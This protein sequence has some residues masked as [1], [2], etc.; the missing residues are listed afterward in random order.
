MDFQNLNTYAYG[1]WPVVAFNIALFAFFAIS[2]IKPKKKVEWGTMGVFI[3]FLAAL[4]TEMYGFPLT[5]F[6]L[7]SYLGVNYPALNP[8]SH[9]SG[10]LTLVFLGLDQSIISLI[11]LHLIS[12]TIIFL[13]LY[14]LHNGWKGIYASKGKQLVK[15]GIYAKIRHPQY[16]GLFLVTIGF[17]IQWP[18]ITTVLMWPILMFAYYRLS[19]REEGD[20]IKKF[21]KE[22]LQ[23]KNRVPAFIPN[24]IF[25]LRS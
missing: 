25:E 15:K 20:M 9:N 12:G 2:F 24:K 14:L 23:Y 10:H 8:F 13:G 3:G 7:S 4:F 16:I 5:I 22:Y 6:F 18:S 21:G 17:L 1:M 19:L 11:I